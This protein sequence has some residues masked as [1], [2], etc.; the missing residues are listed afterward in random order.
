ML[1]QDAQRHQ[2]GDHRFDGHEDV[3]HSWQS[4]EDVLHPEQAAAECD[5][6]RQGIRTPDLRGVSSSL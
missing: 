4:V 3:L 5:G 2:D 6:G 1:Q